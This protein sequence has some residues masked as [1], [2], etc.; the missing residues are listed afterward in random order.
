MAAA[1]RA[2][3]D[4]EE[5]GDINVLM[6]PQGPERDARLHAAVDAYAAL[7]AGDPGHLRLARRAG[8]AIIAPGDGGL[9]RLLATA[10]PAAA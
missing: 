8:N 9:A 10:L 5:A 3:A 1:Q 2:G 7:H 6:E 4:L